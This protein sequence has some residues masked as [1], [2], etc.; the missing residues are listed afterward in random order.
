M[1]WDELADQPCSVAR[2][3]SV[4]G[5]R[6][7][8]LVLCDCFLGVRRFETFRQRLGISRTILADRLAHL[9]ATG[10]LYK[11]AYQQQPL[12]HE[13]RLTDKGLDLHGVVLLL[14]DWGDKYYA[15]KAGP[16]LLRRHHACGHDFSAV[17]TCSECQQALGPRDVEVRTRE[18]RRGVQRVERGPVRQRGPSPSS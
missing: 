5:D 15:G 8:L 12:R 3:L 9:E 2:A 17:V 7:T 11:E 16:P 18:T 1:K 14:A 10:V 13:Y 4:I 6:W